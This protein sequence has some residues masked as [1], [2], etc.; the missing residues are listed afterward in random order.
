M[1][2]NQQSGTVR[3]NR[4]GSSSELQY[5]LQKVENPGKDQ[6]ILKQESIALNFVDILFR[7]GSFPLQ[8]FPATI[9]VEAAGI[10]EA[11]GADV[12][13]FQVGDKAGYYLALGAYAERRT[14]NA[15]SLI[16]LPESVTFDQAASIMAKGLTARMLIKDVYPVKRGDHILVHAAAGGVG[17]LVSQW[18]RSL[19]AIVIGTVGSKAKKEYALAHGSDYV[20]AL[21]SEDVADV[22]KSVTAGK[23]IVAVYDGVGRATFEASVDLVS[24]NGYYV[25]F[26]S[27]SGSPKID[28]ARLNS[29]K[30]TL[31]QPVLGNYLPDHDTV[32]MAA[33][34]LFEALQ[35]GVFGDI[36]PKIYNL[37]DAAAAHKKLESGHTTGST[38]F[39]ID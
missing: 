32:Q 18:A 35:N 23:G 22:V 19:G 15:Q 1:Q 39:H 38:V 12:K 31:V 7:N 30:I 3:I 2:T 21:D 8:D 9:G 36:Q 27:S 16:A 10:I 37:K 4:Q 26:G 13:N 28:K 25:L 29:R 24:E 6:V 14:I 20:I 11:V 5:S 17:S 34:D 33:N